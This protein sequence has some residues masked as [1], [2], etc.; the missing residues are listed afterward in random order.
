MKAIRGSLRIW[1][2]CGSLVAWSQ[3]AECADPVAQG[4][5]R[6]FG[7]RTEISETLT[8]RA[9]ERVETLVLA[10]LQ[11][12]GWTFS[13]TPDVW[14]VTRSSASRLPQISAGSF[15]YGGWYFWAGWAGAGWGATTIRPES[16]PV[17]T[18]MIEVITA[19]NERRVWYGTAA[20]A[21]KRD[22][23]R[24]L[25]QLEKAVVRILKQAP[26]GSP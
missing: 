14:V 13:E 22:P 5:L 10:G 24:R 4:G 26:H 12:R 19:R 25:R 1:L 15:G 6:T 9:P 7:L 2:V 16:I 20:S 18:L 17:E 3:A 21:V 11:A 23:E 8:P